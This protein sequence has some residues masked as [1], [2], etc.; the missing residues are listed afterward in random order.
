MQSKIKMSYKFKT[1]DLNRDLETC[2]KFRRDSYY[3]SFGTHYGFDSEMQD[4]ESR[5]QERISY[6]P[7]GNCHLWCNNLIIAQIEMKLFDNSKI[8]YVSLMYVHPDFRGKSL[9]TLLQKRAISVFS[10]ISK[11]SM[12]LSV[13]NTNIIAQSFYKKHGWISLGPRPNKEKMLL[14]SYSF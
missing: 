13:S 10:N 6:L 14:M 12:Q 5:M 1:I 8:G 7:Q 11:T 3:V 2:I 9:G 4:Y